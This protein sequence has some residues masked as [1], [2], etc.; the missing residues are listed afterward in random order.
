MVYEAFPLIEVSGSPRARGQSY[1]AQA[2][3][4]I[5]KGAGHYVE[6]IRKMGLTQA[7]MAKLIAAFLPTVEKF[8]PAYA[9]EMAGIA[10]GAKIDVEAILL[11]NCRTEILQLARRHAGLLDEPDGCTGAVILPE[12]SLNGELIHGQ[13][14][15]WKA[16]CVETAV[17]LRIRREDGPDLLTFTEAGALARAGFNATGVAITANYL[18]SDRDYTQEGI[19]L[20]L[21]RRKVLESEHLADAIRCVAC[22]PKSA[23]NNMILSAREGFAIDI[24]CAPDEAFTI[25]PENGLITHANHWN[26]PVA[27]SKLKDCGTLST[28]ESHYRDW[29]VRQHLEK[30]LGKLTVDDLREAFFDDFLSPYSVCRPPRPSHAGNIS[31]TVAM[32]LMRPAAGIMEVAPMPARNR[33]FTTYTL[34][35]AERRSQPELNAAE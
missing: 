10:E 27:L 34:E 22:T 33:T 35:T 7:D 14:W 9:E 1:G 12:A 16:E 29:R 28:P 5:H 2:A 11:L 13:N 26:S 18:E 15:D 31:S 32:I 4:R 21:I 6:Q 8:D 20:P 23:S 24:E 17:V 3:G 19:P 25:R 30:K